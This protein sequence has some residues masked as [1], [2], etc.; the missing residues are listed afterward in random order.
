ML[1]PDRAYSETCPGIGSVM[2]SWRLLL[3]TGEARFADLVERTLFNVVATSPGHDGTSFIYANTLHQREHGTV[4]DPDH[5]VGRA[6]SSLRAPWFAVSCCPTNVARTLA[7]V[8]AY[9][10]TVD[11]G[12]LQLHQY[13]PARVSTSL[14]DGR[15]IEVEVRTGY[16]VGGDVHVVVLEDAGSPWTLSLRV[17][18][19]AEGARLEVDGSSKP[20]GPGTVTVHRRFRA[21]ETVVLSLPMAPRLTRPDRR[22]DAVRGCVAV[23]RGPEVLCAESVDLPFD[24]S[25]DEVVLDASAPLRE[26]DGAVTVRGRRVPADEPP[27]PYGTG[28]GTGD[29]Q[30]EEIDLVLRPYHDWANRGPSTMRV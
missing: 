25:V 1:P 22:I 23:E 9:L 30:G 11:D 20:V 2:L 21:G 12:G 5:A 18:A 27:W 17:P 6:A 29:G 8:G 7:S 19:W 10:A 26:V 15:R 24:G 13:A 16:P 3:A 28:D 14:A 4:P